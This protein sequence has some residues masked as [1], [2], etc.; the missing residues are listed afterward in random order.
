M[1]QGKKMDVKVKLGK[2]DSARAETPAKSGS[3]TGHL[4][5]KLGLSVAPLSSMRERI[6]APS[7]INGVVVVAVDEDGPADHAGIQAGDIIAR[8]GDRNVTNGAE[9]ADALTQI[10]QNTALLLVNRRGSTSFLTVELGK[11]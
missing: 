1:R 6:G 8:V 3:G 2:L 4:A 9:L 7:D 11:G 5:P 10:R